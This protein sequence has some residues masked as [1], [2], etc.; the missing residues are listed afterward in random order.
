MAREK[1]FNF[2]KV[3]DHIATSGQPSEEELR[4]LGG[5]G[6]ECILNIA[7]Y[8]HRYS[9][10]D[11]AGLVDSLNME[12]IH[13]PIDFSNPLL[14]DFLEFEKIL[15]R[16]KDEKVLIHCAANYRVSV[17]FSHYASIHL[18]WDERR[19]D[20]FINDIWDIKEFPIWD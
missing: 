17:F 11:E 6:Y 1:V 15:E 5:E 12:Y 13:L 2:V 20:K 4:H 10:T 8:D 3:N 19:C 9:I 7:P 18:G 14:L 16:I